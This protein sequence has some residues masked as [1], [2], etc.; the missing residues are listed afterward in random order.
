[1]MSEVQALTEAQTEISLRL[2]YLRFRAKGGKR[3]G[4]ARARLPKCQRRLEEITRQ[5]EHL[6]TQNHS[7]SITPT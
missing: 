7:S 6:K 3:C 4:K 5:L 1:M 2:A